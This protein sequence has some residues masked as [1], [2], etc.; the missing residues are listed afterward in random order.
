MRFSVLG[1]GSRGNCVF[2]ES[3]RTAILIDGGF[4]GREIGSRLESIGRSLE[5]VD[6]VFVTHEHHDHISGVGVVS[7]RCRIPVFANPGTFAGA[8]KKMKKLFK[9]CEFNTGDSVECKDLC[10]RS[11]TVSHDSN[12]PVGFIVD[13]GRKR[14][15]YCTDT[16]M[17]S[18]LIQQRLADCDGLVLEFNHDP[19][20]LKDGP[21]PLPLKQRVRSNKGHLANE[22]AAKLLSAVR[23]KRL[24]SVVLAHLSETNNLPEIAYRQA[25]SALSGT[26]PQEILKVSEQDLPTELLLL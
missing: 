23:H 25:L 20:M 24:K 3:G 17:V 11:F 16:G 14:L 12:D 7:R 10:I 8:E 5:C 15:G 4:S 26:L 13:D 18:R 6:A 2:I 21:Y 22:D 1:S 19:V 9:R